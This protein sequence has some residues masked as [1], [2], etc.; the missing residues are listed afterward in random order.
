MNTAA[1]TLE[2]VQ[3]AN[4]EAKAAETPAS[5]PEPGSKGPYAFEEVSKDHLKDLLTPMSIPGETKPADEKDQK[6]VDEKPARSETQEEPPAD[7]KGTVETDAKES[8]FSESL[9]ARAESRGY[10]R[11]SIEAFGTPENLKRALD[12]Y[13]EAMKPYLSPQAAPETKKAEQPVTEKQP[14]P[15]A[16]P[17]DDFRIDYNKDDFD[18]SVVAVFDKFEDAIK[19][20]RGDIKQKDALINEL[21]GNVEQNQS[22]DLV[23][24]FESFIADLGKDYEPYVGKGKV[25]NLAQSELDTRNEIINEINIAA[26]GRQARGL[27]PLSRKEYFDRAVKVVLGDKLKDIT[28]KRISEKV[29][30]ASKRFIQKTQR[31]QDIPMTGT[32]AAERAVAELMIA[33]G[34]KV[35]G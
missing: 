9:I 34:E 30:K 7:Y 5:K 33:K 17:E 26:A 18:P 32:Q 15:A 20:L 12:A 2:Q 4:A 25:G 27:P 6:A 21:K 28:E 13:D 11:E 16:A 35:Y 8:P 19:G 10:A 22:R 31:D 3:E 14:Q 29:D 1:E 23:D 24:Q